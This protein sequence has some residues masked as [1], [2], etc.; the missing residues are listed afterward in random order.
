ME[1]LRSKRKKK[2]K[3]HMTPRNRDKHEKNEQ[4]LN[5]I[6]EEGPGQSELEDADR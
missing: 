6:R 4:Q 3:E 1:S 5:R 2:T